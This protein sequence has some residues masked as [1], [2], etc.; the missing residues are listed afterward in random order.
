[1]SPE[2]ETSQLI[3]LKCI[4]ECQLWDAQGRFYD[5]WGAVWMG[6]ALHGYAFRGV[7]TRIPD[8]GAR[9]TRET[10]LSEL[11]QIVCF[12]EHVFI[13]VAIEFA[14]FIREA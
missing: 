5:A 14:T 13:L 12:Q 11:E 7:S 1:M 6:H 9:R 2:F 3:W 4:A 8:V 10:V